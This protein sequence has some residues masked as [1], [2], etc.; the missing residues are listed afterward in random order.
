MA[1]LQFDIRKARQQASAIEEAAEGLSRLTKYQYAA[2]MQGVQNSWK[3]ENAE[4]YLKKAAKLQEKMENTS[5]QLNETAQAVRSAAR[6][7][8]LAEQTAVRLSETR[9][10]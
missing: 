5:R 8:E 7:V 2:T 3:G 1:I 6:A 10:Y 9:G 4:C